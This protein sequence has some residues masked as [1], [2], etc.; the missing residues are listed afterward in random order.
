MQTD[1]T[2]V[3]AYLGKEEVYTATILDTQLGGEEHAV[4]E[5]FLLQFGPNNVKGLLLSVSTE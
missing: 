2:K 4:L 5:A 3:A 1:S